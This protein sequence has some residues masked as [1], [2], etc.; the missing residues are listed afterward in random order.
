M[1]ERTGGNRIQGFG[2]C[3]TALGNI[4]R[5]WSAFS[6]RPHASYSRTIRWPASATRYCARRT[7]TFC[8]WQGLE[9]LVA[10]DEK[11]FGGSIVFLTQQSVTE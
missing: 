11:R 5:H 8:P 9:A 1:A 6:G 3:S 4:L 7:G 2:L 10:L